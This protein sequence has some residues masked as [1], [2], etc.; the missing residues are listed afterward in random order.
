VK[1]IDRQHREL[2]ARVNALFEA[3]GR[4]D[5]GEE[6]ES[7]VAFLKGYVHTH[8]ACE[9]RLMRRHGYPGYARHLSEHQRFVDELAWIDDLYDGGSATDT[10]VGSTARFL[11]SWLSEHFQRADRD[12]ADYL[13]AGGVHLHPSV[14]VE[15][16]RPRKVG[17]PGPA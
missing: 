6:I 16:A 14:A 1:G 2:L 15:A 3:I 12:L 5:S 9:E 10:R 7:L 13:R 8:F 4:G 17:A 11:A